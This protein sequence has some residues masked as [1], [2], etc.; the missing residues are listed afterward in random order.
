MTDSIHFTCPHCA[1]TMQFPAAVEGKQGKCPAC[2]VVVTVANNAMVDLASLQQDATPQQVAPSPARQADPQ[3]T[4]QQPPASE[5]VSLEM[6][7]LHFAE[8]NLATGEKI[9]H[10]GRCHPC[11]KWICIISFLT[12]SIGTGIFLSY[13]G[14]GN[15]RDDSEHFLANL[16]MIICACSP[17]FTVIFGYIY[18][19]ITRTELV[20]TNKRL[21]SRQGVLFIKTRDVQLKKVGSIDFSRGPL[22]ALFG[23]GRITIR[24]TGGVK[25]GRFRYLADAL[26]FRRRI[27]AQIDK[28]SSS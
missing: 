21:L 5:D 19:D 14:I 27:L 7:R 13:L 10:A 11:V 22:E 17:W 6:G 2:K 1:H 3:S 25:G 24:N 15:N 23:C 9:I 8:R 28:A 26:E 4:V 12:S 18:L 20:L 16:L